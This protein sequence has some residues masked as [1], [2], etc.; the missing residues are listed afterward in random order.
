MLA[1]GVVSISLGDPPV[2]TGC[3]LK[4][5]TASFAPVHPSFILSL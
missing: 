1:G 4:G 2:L 3:D 5:Q